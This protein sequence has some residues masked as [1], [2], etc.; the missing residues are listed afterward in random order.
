MLNQLK[1]Q[2]GYFLATILVLAAALIILST[3]LIY[4][5]INQKIYF[6]RS[7]EKTSARQIGE[8]GI[9]YYLWHLAHDPNDYADGT[10]ETCT[11]VCGP[12]IHSY[13]NQAGETVGSFSLEIAPP[14]T[15]ENFATVTSTGQLS[16][17]EETKAIRAKLGIPSFARF[18]QLAAE[19]YIWIG[20]NEITRGPVHSNTQ[21]RNDGEA[22]D[23]VTASKTTHCKPSW[24]CNPGV[25]GSGIFHA[26]YSYPVPEIDF[27]GVTADLAQIKSDAQETEGHYFAD[28]GDEGYHIYLTGS[29]FSLYR[30]TQTSPRV[31]VYTQSGYRWA[32]D[33]IASEEFLGNYSFPENDLIFVEDDLW[34]EGTIDDAQIT[35]AAAR[36]PENPGTY[37]QIVINNNLLYTNKDG[38]D[39]IGLITQGFITYPYNA[40]DNIEINGALLCQRGYIEVHY[41]YSQRRLYDTITY[42]GSAASLGEPGRAWVSGGQIVHGYLNAEFTYDE[43]LTFGPPPSFPTTGAYTIMSWE[44]L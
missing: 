3:A 7:R 6:E 13:Q 30:V 44:E 31:R 36:L 32:T 17:S 12:Y 19:D 11:D 24:G 18:V 35:I 22:F 40:P 21:V 4:A 41:Y 27:N 43:Y 9:N 23:L 10:G 26:G 2:G 14:E 33:D 37:A 38:T 15:G 1:K 25:F 16:G 39:K 20:Q 5:T 8:A 28:S 42:Y 29:N 34:I